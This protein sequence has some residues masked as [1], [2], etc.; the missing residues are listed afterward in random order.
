MN[1]LNL[2]VYLIIW[3]FGCHVHAQCDLSR[4]SYFSP[5]WSKDGTMISFHANIHGNREVYL[6]NEDGSSLKRL[7]ETAEQ[8]RVPT[9]SPDGQNV[10]FFR[11]NNERTFSHLIS[12]TLDTNKENV[13]GDPGYQ[14]FDPHWMSDMSSITFVS[15]RDDSWEIYRLDS[16]DNHA[17]RLTTNSVQDYSPL[18]SPDGS[19]IAYIS[20]ESGKPDIWIMN[21]D[22]TSKI[23]LT[24]D[25]NEE[26][27][28]GW[29]P[30][31]SKI[32]YSSRK[33]KSQFSGLESGS[34]SNASN[35]SSEIYILEIANLQNKQLT[36]N[37]HLDTS[38]DWSPDGSRV[39]Y[40]SCER[41]YLE[42]YL[43]ELHTLKSK[44]LMGR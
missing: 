30:D 2:L 19:K 35:N 14:N 26:I 4:N 16:N 38:P 11:R 12:L 5:R 7:T 22:G 43:L 21:A 25:A 1:K 33:P 18:F 23:N 10:L 29:S 17:V 39:V 15:D 42:L 13:I 36:K 37:D 8:E 44:P 41:G 20:Q 34:R 3:G 32:I 27:S 28:F 6:V 9:I 31:G 40:C 24:P